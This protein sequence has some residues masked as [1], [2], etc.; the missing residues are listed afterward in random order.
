MFLS[1][2][3]IPFSVYAI[4]KPSNRTAKGSDPLRHDN[5]HFDELSQSTQLNPK[6]LSNSTQVTRPAN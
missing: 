6:Q 2:L 4:S 1:G 3:N 5:S